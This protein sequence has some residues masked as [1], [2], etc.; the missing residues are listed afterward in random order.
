MIE[1]RCGLLC[2]ECKYRETMKCEGCIK[3]SKPYWAKTCPIK[4]CCEGK[5]LV[6]CGQCDKF[7]CKQLHEFAFDPATNEEGTR[8]EQCTD[9]QAIRP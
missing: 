9:W 4:T 6:H 7:P 8:I 3:I 1:S 2:S 5:K